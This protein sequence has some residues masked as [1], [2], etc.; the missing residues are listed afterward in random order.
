MRRESQKMRRDQKKRGRGCAFRSLA[1]DMCLSFILSV[2]IV[3]PLVNQLPGF[4]SDRIESSTVLLYGVCYKNAK[5]VKPQVKSNR[6][7][8]HIPHTQL[9]P[10]KYTKF[11]LRPNEGI[12]DSYS[13]DPNHAIKARSAHPYLKNSPSFQTGRI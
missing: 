11:M 5:D 3:L 6:L 9:N 7:D 10:D 4:G 8:L 1:A 2:I 13:A 12:S